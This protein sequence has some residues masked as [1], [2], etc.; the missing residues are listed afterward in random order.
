[1]DLDEGINLQNIEEIGGS[2]FADYCNLFIDKFL[3][4]AT[5]LVYSKHL[6]L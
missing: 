4:G 1:M 5:I 6:S 3:N 2:R